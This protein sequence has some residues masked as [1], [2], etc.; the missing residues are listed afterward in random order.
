MGYG[1]RYDGEE[2][3]WEL[4]YAFGEFFRP[5]SGAGMSFVGPVSVPSL[6]FRIVYHSLESDRLA[7]VVEMVLAADGS[8][9]SSDVYEATVRSRAKL[10][11][12]SVADWLE[13]NGADATRNRRGQRSRRESSAPGP[14]GPEAESAAAP[15]RCA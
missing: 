15:Q 10:A 1:R 7:I 6:D 12:N 11:Y 9:V 3:G 5:A 8:L 4:F 14:R 2:L 13:G